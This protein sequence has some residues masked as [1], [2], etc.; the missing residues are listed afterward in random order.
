[1]GENRCIGG[2]GQ[3]A[4][5]VD[6]GV[7]TDAVACT[8]PVGGNEPGGITFK[9]LQDVELNLGPGNNLFTIHDTPP[10]T[11][12][13][14]NTGAGD[15]VVNVEKI[16]GHTFVN[17]G[18]GNDVVNIHNTQQQLSDLLGLL[19]V[20]RRQ[21]A[22]ERDQP[23][24]RLAA[25]GHR[26]RPGRCRAEADRRRHRRDLHAEL[27]A[28]AAAADG[29]AGCREHRG[30]LAKGT[31]FYVV[32]AVIDGVETLA[33]PETFDQTTS[34]NGKVD[35]SWYP[36]PL[37]NGGYKIYR[38]TTAGGENVL[39][40]TTMKTSFVDNGS[41]SS[42]TPPTT[43]ATIH[44]PVTL[45]YGASAATVQ[46]ALETLLGSGNVKVQKA[47]DV[48]NIFFQGA[49]AGTAIPL[50]FAD[51]ANLT[52]GAGEV[53]RLNI[54][55]SGSTAAN[56]AALLTST[57]LT[58][59]DMP[60]SNQIQ[61]LVLDATGGTFTLTY[62]FPLVALNVAASTGAA[63][64][65]LG[66]GHALLRRHRYHVRT[67]R[68]SPRAEVAALTA[69]GGSVDL[70]WD[71]VA[72]RLELSRLPR[73]D[74]GSRERM[75]GRRDERHEAMPFTDTGDPTCRRPQHAGHAGHDA[76]DADRLRPP[77]DDDARRRP[78]VE[79]LCGRRPARTRAAPG[80]RRR[81]RRRDEERRRLRDPLPGHAERLRAL[82]A[83]GRLQP[84]A[85]GER[86]NLG[87][88]V[89]TAGR[90]ASM[91]T[92][93]TRG[94]GLLRPGDEPGSAA[95][96]RRDE[97]HVRPL[98]PRRP[99]PLHDAADRVQRERG[100]SCA[101][102]SRMRSRSASRPIRT[103]ACTPPTRST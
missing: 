72:G 36:V 57:S 61:Q 71:A 30:T 24:E 28:D 95:D 3:A 62:T 77:D 69:P 59:L 48:Y 31:Y 55:D 96:G 50:L 16:E 11:L 88:T 44:T 103:H 78:A 35:L 2:P 20:E 37:A 17:L 80:N 25:A 43:S 91:A 93:T 82:A 4:G 60:A 74:A 67:A 83:Q 45:N 34:A 58:G 90:A 21:P 15:D 76:A 99:A 6:D 42:A 41:G 92:I 47:G 13:R 7:L 94:D 40:G 75:A 5:Q 46:S 81:Q 65:T 19:T 9:G 66:A 98:V 52:S 86:A 26:G 85:E 53:D 97:R 84:A 23:H 33:S 29:V 89:T 100:S 56:D 39:V 8:G 79:R 87:G 73:C 54:D 51:A 64:G 1:M 12:V 68:R 10:S 32:T 38:G 70:T 63:A 22:G 18:A 14:V 101:R 49:F 102:R 27:R